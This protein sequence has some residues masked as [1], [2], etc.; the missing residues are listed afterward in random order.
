MLGMPWPML[1][2]AESICSVV[3]PFLG[4]NAAM[5][6]AREYMHDKQFA[7]DGRPQA[8][9][10]PTLLQNLWSSAYLP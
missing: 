2:T 1:P 5:L 7:G 6:H 9:Q 8:A 10:Q 3:D 4:I